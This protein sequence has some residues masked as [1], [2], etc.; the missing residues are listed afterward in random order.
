MKIFSLV[1]SMA[2]VSEMASQAASSFSDSDKTLANDVSV[3]LAT[4]FE[5]VSGKFINGPG[6]V[7][8]AATVMEG[9]DPKVVIFDEEKGFGLFTTIDLGEESFRCLGLSLVEMW[10]TP[11]TYKSNSSGSQSVETQN[12]RAVPEFRSPLLSGFGLLLLWQRR[13]RRVKG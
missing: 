6:G 1:I 10:N 11:G 13:T 7:L 2:L 9:L 3:G 8:D 12:I 5:A 4:P